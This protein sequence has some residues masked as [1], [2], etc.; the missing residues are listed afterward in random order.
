MIFE[1]CLGIIVCLPSIFV[2]VAKTRKAAV[3][4]WEYICLDPYP[5]FPSRHEICIKPMRI[6]RGQR[7]SRQRTSVFRMGVISR[8]Y[9]LSGAVSAAMC[10]GIEPPLYMERCRNGIGEDC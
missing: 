4:K 10:A 2:G 6:I 1:L 7:K 8:K 3:G 5:I 9:K